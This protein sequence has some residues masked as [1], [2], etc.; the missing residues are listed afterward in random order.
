[1]ARKFKVEKAHCERHDVD[2]EKL[3]QVRVSCPRYQHKFFDIFYISPTALG[4]FLWL[5][6]QVL[7]Y[8]ECRV[9]PI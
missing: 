7:S 1:M 4:Y 9:S 8:R 5:E 3:I 6:V 2:F